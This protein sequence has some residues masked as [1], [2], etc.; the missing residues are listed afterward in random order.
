MFW[1]FYYYVAILALLSQGVFLAQTFRNYYYALKKAFC[2]HDYQPPALLTVPCKGLDN[3]FEANISSLF[4][5]D[6]DNYFLNFVVESTDDPAYEKLCALKE[7]LAPA[8]KARHIQVLL[9]GNASGC[10]QK[11]HNLLYSCR[12]RPEEVEIFAFAD[13]DVRFRPDWLRHLAYPLRKP[14]YGASTGYRWFIPSKNNL[15]SLALSAINGKV[16]QM[17]GNTHFN[18]LWGG[19]MAVRRETFE[20][21]EIEKIWSKA[22]SDDLS[23][24]SAIKKTGMKIIY[25]PGCLVA[26]YESTTWKK[27]FEFVTRQFIITRVAMPATWWFGL[28]CSTYAL[29]G[30]WLGA[31]I[32]ILALITSQPYLPLYL[33]VPAFFFVGQFVRAVLR[34][35]MITKLL[36]NDTKETTP[37]V[38]ADIL[39]NCLWSW[40]MFLCIFTSAFRRTITWRGIKYKLISPTETIIVKPKK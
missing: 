1:H 13:S 29:S 39:G 28:F 17:L 40:L 15:A 33:S 25:T 27:L 23:L 21:L 11:I 38:I 37:A 19:S 6:Y 14:Q 24:S 22:I 16:A 8:S 26:S 3:S 2:K 31:A 18:Q 12:N 36:P 7:K 4:N 20:R 35:K 10:G 34:Q 30:L 5:L 9:A 32:A